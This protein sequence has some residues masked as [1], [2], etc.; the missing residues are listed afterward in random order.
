[1]GNASDEL[2]PGDSRR[3]LQPRARSGDGMPTTGLTLG[4]RQLLFHGLAERP[5]VAYVQPPTTNWPRRHRLGT[6]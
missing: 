1:M 4:R 6:K 3:Q 2:S 5:P